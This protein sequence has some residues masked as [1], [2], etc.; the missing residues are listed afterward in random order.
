MSSP[1]Y[2]PDHEESLALSEP[3]CHSIWSFRHHISLWRRTNCSASFPSSSQ[4]SHSVVG[5]GIR[6]RINCTEYR[7]I[8]LFVVYQ[9]ILYG[10]EEFSWYSEQDELTL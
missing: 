9:C 5:I 2:V 6:R 10:D 4:R 1:S 3:L 7:R 8:V